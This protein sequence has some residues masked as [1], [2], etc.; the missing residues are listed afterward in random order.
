MVK[1]RRQYDDLLSLPEIRSAQ[2]AARNLDIVV[3]SGTEWADVHSPLRRLLRREKNPVAEQDDFCIGDLLWSP[4]DKNGPISKGPEERAMTLLQLPDLPSMIRKGARVVLMLA[5]C[6]GRDS[7]ENRP[8]EVK[9]CL[10]DKGT[11]LACLLAQPKRYLTDV[12]VDPVTAA[13]ALEQ[14]G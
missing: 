7:V 8:G 13:V 12:V 9:H 4:I 1:T 3:T 11:L 6:A 2:I 5:P 10:R 14:L